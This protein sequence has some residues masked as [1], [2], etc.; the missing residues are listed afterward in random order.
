V[1]D[2]RRRRVLFVT[3]TT[4]YQAKAF[5][6]AAASLD[7]E[8][9]YATD[10]CH[11]L[12]DPWGDRAI[13]VDFDNPPA[14]VDAIR[15]AAAV[16]RIDGVLAA[17]DRPARLAADAAA[18]LGLPWHSIAGARASTNKLL[19]RGRFLAAGLPVPWFFAMPR[20]ATL[21]RVAD[22]LRFPCVIKPMALGGS[23]GVIR[24]DDP[25]AFE[26]ACA[27]VRAILE[28]EPSRAAPDPADDELLVEGFLPGHEY[29]LEGVLEGGA[30]RVLAIFDKPDPLDGPLFAETIYVTPPPLART[31]ERAIAGTIAHAAAALGLHHGPIHAECRVNDAGIF[32]LEIAPRPIGGLCARALRFATERRE[33]IS[34]EELLLR[35]ALGEPLE[36][37]GRGAG[38]SGV[39]MLPVPRAGRLRRIGGIEEARAVPGIDEVVVTAHVDEQLVPLPEGSSYLGFVF[40]RAAEPLDAVA[41]LRHAHAALRFDIDAPIPMA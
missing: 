38:A 29:A 35:H 4:G 1:T 26:R 19:A 23:R 6:S 32:V 41:A 28:S 40:A 8:L 22:R 33:G 34:L 27:R 16:A 10:R 31:A 13:P 17:G 3:A 18:A 21:A 7:V 2:H 24:A 11:V 9:I 5:E 20:D 39:L 15:R 14:S 37:F 36:G 30:L 12:D 25:V